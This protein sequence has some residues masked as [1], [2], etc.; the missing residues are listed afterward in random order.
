MVTTL[1]CLEVNYPLWF[2]LCVIHRSIYIS[3]EHNII[4]F[5]CLTFKLCRFSVSVRSGEEGYYPDLTLFCEKRIECLAPGSRALR[6]DKPAATAAD[7]TTE[8][9]EE[10]NGEIKV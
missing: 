8:E 10:I 5:L 4:C 6:K 9:W 3:G 2:L 7:F 1:S